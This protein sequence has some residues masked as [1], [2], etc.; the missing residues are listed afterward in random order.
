MKRIFP[1][2]FYN[3]VTLGGA[4]IAS[5]SFVLILFLILLEMLTKH[6]KPYMGIIAFVIMP[7]FLILGLVV[8]GVGIVRENR[9]ERV[10]A[11]PE[12]RLPS[13]DLNNP[14]HRVAFLVFSV[15][16]ILLLMLTAFGSFKA[17]EYT[18][19]DQF[20]GEVCHKVMEPEYTAY[21]FSPH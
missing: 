13:I 16:T 18:D 14:R 17:Y 4:A 6:Q 2:S 10:G 8:I 19:S 7:A 12:M 20:C 9:R 5:V 11:P 15:G 21:L 3:P 1:R